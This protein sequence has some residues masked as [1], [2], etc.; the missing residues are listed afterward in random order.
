MGRGDERI[1]MNNLKD[2]EK[3]TTRLKICLECD[4]CLHD[5]AIKIAIEAL[6]ENIKLKRF[7][8]IVK[9]RKPYIYLKRNASKDR[10]ISDINSYEE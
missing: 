9:S 5:G 8:D 1:A 4:D 3:A 10:Y 2:I 7:V 6:E